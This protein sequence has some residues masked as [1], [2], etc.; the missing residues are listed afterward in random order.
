MPREPKYDIDT[1]WDDP[2]EHHLRHGERRVEPRGRAKFNVQI[3]VQWPGHRRL[4]SSKAKHADSPRGQDLLLGGMTPELLWPQQH[5]R[6][7][8]QAVR[9]SHWCG[10]R[11]SKLEPGQRRR[12]KTDTGLL[13]YPRSRLLRCCRG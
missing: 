2:Y 10:Q 13:L 4:S 5:M 7:R 8:L 12:H 3:A 11:M 6:Q 9:L 1:E